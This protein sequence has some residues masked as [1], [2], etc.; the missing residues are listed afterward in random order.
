MQSFIKFEYSM[1]PGGV[2]GLVPT[3]IEMTLQASD[4]S[5]TEVMENFERFLLAI[6]YQEGSIQ[7]YYEAQ[8]EPE[9]NICQTCGAEEVE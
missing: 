4:A 9:S 8:W 5:V 1:E 6:G 7:D 2:D 3:D